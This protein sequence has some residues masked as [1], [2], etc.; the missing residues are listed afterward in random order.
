MG[1]G[2]DHHAQEHAEHFHTPQHMAAETTQRVH[3]AAP[4][5]AAGGTAGAGDAAAGGSP[6][7][8]GINPAVAWLEADDDPTGP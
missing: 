3:A 6:E 1:T 8:P 5:E 4:C 2:T 7:L